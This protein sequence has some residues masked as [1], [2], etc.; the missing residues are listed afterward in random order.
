[1]SEQQEGQHLH[2][3]ATRGE[4]LSSQEE[5]VLAAWYAALDETEAALLDAN[6]D[7][8][9]AAALREQVR[10]SARRVQVVAQQVEELTVANE[11][12]RRDIA[13]AQRRLAQA[14]TARTA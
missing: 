1:M 8:G 13:A 7:P 5:Q 14:R 11:R 10:A 4:V 2:D 12:L 3:R 9:A 6:H